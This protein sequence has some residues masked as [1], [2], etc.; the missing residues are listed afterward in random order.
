MKKKIVQA[1][2]PLRGTFKPPGDKSIAHRAALFSALSSDAREC[3]FGNYAPGADCRSTLACI[4]ALGV[5]TELT[6]SPPTLRITSPGLRQ[7][8]EPK[9]VLDCGNS[10]TTMRLLC[11]LLASRPFY[12]VLSG[13]DSLQG[14][15]MLRITAPLQEMGAHILGRQAGRLAPLS[16]VGGNL[17][18]ISHRSKVASAQVKSAIL[19][20]GLFAEGETQVFEPTLSRDHTERMLSYFNVEITTIPSDSSGYTVKVIG[21]NTVEPRSMEIPGDVS[22]AAFFI[23]AA[24]LIKGS[25]LI[26]KDVG[27]NPTRTGFLSALNKMDVEL[28]ITSFQHEVEPMGDILVKSQDL[29]PFSLEGEEIPSLIDEVPILAVLATQAQGVSVIKDAQELRVKECD[30][31]AA[32]AQNLQAMGANIEEKEDGLIIEG[33]TPLKGAL[34]DSYDDHRIAMASAVAGYIAQG[35]TV[36]ENAEC[37]S[38]SLPGFYET[39]EKLSATGGS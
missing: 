23:A 3:T 35:E 21:N 18:G 7:L 13:D 9:T 16:I 10:G 29:Q 4:G 5:K 20:A 32:I 31:L 38:V 19:L 27:L 6:G 2:G 17:Q 34:L 33:P 12:S 22:S 1:T 30:R 36:I 24:L 8:Q 25:Q 11:G 15:P 39:L 37:A 28:E 26:I 14:R